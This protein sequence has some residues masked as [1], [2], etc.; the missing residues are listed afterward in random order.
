MMDVLLYKILFQMI[1][2]CNLP[3]N[4]FYETS[5]TPTFSQGFS[6]KLFKQRAGDGTEDITTHNR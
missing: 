1:I 3:A 6:W 5:Q 2:F 4:F